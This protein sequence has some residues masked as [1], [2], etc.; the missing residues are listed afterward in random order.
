MALEMEPNARFPFISGIVE[1]LAQARVRSD[2]GDTKMTGC[3]YHWFYEEDKS[4][5]NILA[6]F[7]RFQDRAPG[8][9]VDALIRRRCGE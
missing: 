2:G 3:I 8:A 7:A 5:D 9:I 1:G 6:A 4:Y